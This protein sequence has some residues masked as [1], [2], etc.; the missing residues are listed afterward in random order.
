MADKPGE[1]DEAVA[2]EADKAKANEANDNEAIVTNA[3]NKANV[4]KEA[5]V[6]NK[7]VA[8][9]EAID[10]NASSIGFGNSIG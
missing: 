2:D 10:N 5:N 9:D 7:I 6:I 4:A 8:A 1:A 3:A